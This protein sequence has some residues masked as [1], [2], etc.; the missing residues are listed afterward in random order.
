MSDE[1]K[2]SELLK[3]LGEVIKQKNDEIVYLR[4]R[5]ADLERAL[6]NAEEQ[7][8]KAAAANAIAIMANDAVIAKEEKQG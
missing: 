4:F 8:E 7:L 5:N 3:E 6:R 2:Y 1:Q